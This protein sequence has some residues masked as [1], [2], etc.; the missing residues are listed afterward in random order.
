M[1]TSDR[2][3]PTEEEIEEIV[4]RHETW[5][6]TN[7][8]EGEKANLV[9]ADLINVDLRDRNLRETE[10]QGADLSGATLD[11]STLS[12]IDLC[13]ACLESETVRRGRG[14]VDFQGATLA[15]LGIQ[16]L[17]DVGGAGWTW[18]MR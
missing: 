4:N 13:N 11:N 17:Y 3:E 10:L 7:H 16:L 12:D 2:W 15:G 1:N 5:L 14:D 8:E 6:R 9:G 18:G